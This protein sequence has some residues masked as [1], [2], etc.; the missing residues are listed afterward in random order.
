[1][2]LALASLLVA[3]VASSPAPAAPASPSVQAQLVLG[4]AVSNREVQAL[5]DQTATAGQTVYAWTEIKDA[6]GGTVEHV[7]S[8]N[9]KQLARHSLTVGNSKR[10][11]TWS[12]QKVVAGSCQVEVLTSDGTRLQESTFQVTP[13]AR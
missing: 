8:C 4:S 2:S 11:R 12:H 9:G 13:A 10:W 6:N 7:W 5:A 3:A 1:M